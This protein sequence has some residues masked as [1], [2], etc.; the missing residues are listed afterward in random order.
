[1]TTDPRRPTTEAVNSRLLILPFC[2]DAIVHKHAVTLRQ[3]PGNIFD[4]GQSCSLGHYRSPSRVHGRPNFF[5]PNYPTTP[6]ASTRLRSALSAK[7]YRRAMSIVFC[8]ASI[9][10]TCLPQGRPNMRRLLISR[11]Q[12]HSASMCR[13]HCSFARMGDRIA[14]FLLQRRMSALGDKADINREGP[15]TT[16]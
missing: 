15:S 12:R 6:I 11:L 8:A 3:L 16:V 14:T 4:V 1:M 2:M 9:R 7:V 10:L 13:H 5:A